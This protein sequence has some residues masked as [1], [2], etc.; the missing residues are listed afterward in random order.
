MLDTIFLIAAVVGGT[1]LICQFALTLLGMGHDGAD[2]GHDAGDFSVDVHAGGD[3][4]GDT[5]G[6]FH[7]DGGGIAT[8]HHHTSLSTAA[9]A[10][11]QHADSSWL[12]GVLS[13]RTLV[14]AA[15]FFGVAGKAATS[16]GYS[17]FTSLVVAT[18]VGVAA[19]YGMYWLMQLISR[20]NSSGNESIRN[21]LGCSATVYVPIP[22]GRKGAGKV[23]MSMQN[24]IVEYLA[25]T[26]DDTTL[27]TGEAAEVI[28]IAGSDTVRVRRAGRVVTA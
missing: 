7:A 17:Q 5:G 24:R 3:F 18:L 2:A 15:A 28:G 23:Q 12:F 9:D 6:A 26:D 11:F 8:D 25:V 4:H 14:A 21:A 27:K 16:A 10:E 20:L 19:M 13:F 1:V 22:A